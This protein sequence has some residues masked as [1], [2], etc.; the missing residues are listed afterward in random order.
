MLHAPSKTPHFQHPFAPKLFLS[1][2][3]AVI[4][5]GLAAGVVS[6]NKD[7]PDSSSVVAPPTTAK[8]ATA[9]KAPPKRPTLTAEQFCSQVF[10]AAGRHL[11]RHCSSEDKK[12]R[13]YQRLDKLASKPAERCVTLL[14]PSVKAG[15]LELYELKA[16]ACA[17]V[18]EKTSWKDTML[19]AELTRFPECRK[20]AAGTQAVGQPC[21]VSEECT[22][23][24][25][26]A[27]ASAT[28][29]G[30]CVTAAEV[31]GGCDQ[32]RVALGIPRRSCRRGA[33]CAIPVGPPRYALGRLAHEPGEGKTYR[34]RSKRAPVGSPALRDAAEFG[35]IGLLNSGAGGDPD[36]P[37]AP[38][39]TDDSLGTDPLSLSKVSGG[40]GEGIGL[41]SIGTI[42]HGAGSG[43]GQGF[44]SGSGRLGRSRRARPPRIRMGTVSVSGR[45]PPKVIRRIVRQNFG[46]FR[47]CYENGLRNNPNLQGRITVRFVIGRDGRVSN[48]VGGGDL[49]NAGVVSCV[50]RSFYGLTFPRP[51]GGIVT[52]SYP[53]VFSPGDRPKG[54]RDSVG[55]PQSK[56]A[57]IPDGASEQQFVLPFQCD[58]AKKKGEPCQ[59]SV[60]CDMGL[61]CRAGRCA[62]A[63]SPGKEGDEC[64]LEEDCGTGHYCRRDASDLD[65]G[66]C[67]PRKPS[68]AKCTS[69]LQ[70][71]GVCNRDKK[72]CV[73]LCGAG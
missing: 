67:K 70:C 51:K 60:H 16:K 61:I 11:A 6:C 18:L 30:K 72:Q 15:R 47:L 65:K 64:H 48:V 31:G 5:L 41:G 44:G 13:A 26:C 68:G 52:V 53:I 66:L 32:V 50:K 28:S 3:V 36:A 55:K 56:D 33:A 38:W 4:C 9:S 24:L 49:P 22:P 20:L 58:V 63:D 39:G 14:G 71:Q 8:T 7:N 27:G 1:W 35:M 62:N 42:G 23:G 40:R 21:R 10:G 29:D 37:T 57:G 43:T 59:A 2:S 45:L 34:P 46:R 69:S 25:W 54:A 17:A 19:T 12:Q 73:P